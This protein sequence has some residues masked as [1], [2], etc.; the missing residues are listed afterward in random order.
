MPAPSWLAPLD[1]RLLFFG[2]DAENGSAL[3]SSNGTP[4]GTG[5]LHRLDPEHGA[6]SDP[7]Q[8]LRLGDSLFVTAIDGET[9]RQLWRVDEESQVAERVTE[10][11]TAE[12][13]PFLLHT[14]GAAGGKVVLYE[15]G[16]ERLLAFDPGSG[17]SQ[18]LPGL[19]INYLEPAATL[20]D[21]LVLPG[22]ELART[23]G[24]AAG[25]FLLGDFTPGECQV[26]PRFRAPCPSEAASLTRF[27]GYVYYTARSFEW[28][29]ELFRTDGTVEGTTLVA[30]LWP[31]GGGSEPHHLTAVDDRLYFVASTPP[32]STPELW[33]LEAGASDPRRGVPRSLNLAA[34]AAFRGRL[35]VSELA[36]EGAPELW[37]TDG[38]EVGSTLLY[39]GESGW[40]P[41][42]TL[43]ASGDRLLFAARGESGVEPWVSDGTI[44]GTRPLR[45]IAVGPASSLPN[46][47]RD[48]SLRPVDGVFTFAASDGATGDELWSSDPDALDALFLGDLDDGPSSAYPAE[49]TPLGDRVFFAA[50]RA[51]VGREL[52]AIDRSAFVRTCRESATTLCLHGGRFAVSVDWL[53][54]TSGAKGRAGAVP[55]TEETGLFWFFEE[56]NLELAVKVLDGRSI[57]GSFWVYYGALTDVEY[58]VT[59]VDT[60]TG[61]SRTLHSAQGTVCGRGDVH[62]LPDQELVVG[63]ASPALVR[64][65]GPRAEPAEGTRSAAAA[66]D[67]MRSLCLHEGRF[68]VDVIWRDPNDGAESPASPIHDTD[69][70]GAFWFFEPT[71]LELLVKVLDGRTINGRF[72]VY[73]GAL[74]DVAY[75][76]R[77]TDTSTGAT[78][79][80]RNPPGTLCGNADVE[81]F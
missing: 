70:T 19:T 5:F 53:D 39:R 58:W 16:G 10:L 69:L 7:T 80:Y 3:W 62:A 11:G 26:A 31:N 13:R 20:D 38:T 4:G 73:F 9:G 61:R 15:N 77:V 79:V 59:V 66:C 56:D 46:L 52:F 25:T 71:N 27:G 60:V 30:D 29:R 43:I 54:R 36:N 1:D 18:V 32:S 44:E 6:S 65:A 47:F 40:P 63:L 74:S 48:P 21:L 37:L 2:W 33:Y 42:R 68:A 34:T 72:W 28:G 49:L 50:R 55:R 23:D 75:E 35:V 22:T 8:F 17:E 12:R 57:T 76:I 14:L 64:A 24:T 81:A 41:P 67:P 45:D 78:R 51:D